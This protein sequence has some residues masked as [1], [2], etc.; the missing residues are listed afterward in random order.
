MLWLRLINEIFLAND[1]FL[2]PKYRSRLVVRL[3]AN[4]YYLKLLYWFFFYI[5]S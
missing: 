4:K 2:K 5:C 1:S 3:K